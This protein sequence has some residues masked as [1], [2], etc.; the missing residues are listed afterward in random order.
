MHVCLC[1]Y[2][3]QFIVLRKQLY[4][5]NVI[6]RGQQLLAALAFKAEYAVL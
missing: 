5:E 2:H 3:L 4:I 6:N 1:V